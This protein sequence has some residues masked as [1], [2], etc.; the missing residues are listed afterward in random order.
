[1]K[2]AGFFIIT[3]IVIHKYIVGKQSVETAP[4]SGY[5]LIFQTLSGLSD[6][7]RFVY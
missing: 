6:L 4:Q 7:L 3:L 2:D 1:M 5:W